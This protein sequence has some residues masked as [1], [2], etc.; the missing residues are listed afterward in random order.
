MGM[1]M[2]DVP[3]SEPDPGNLESTKA[4]PN[5]EKF[6][7]LLCNA[8]VQR[9]HQRTWRERRKATRLTLTQLALGLEHLNNGGT[10]VVLLHKLN[11]WPCFTSPEPSSFYLVAKN[12]QADSTLAKALVL[13]W[14][15]RYKVAT[16]GTDEKS[17]DGS[18]DNGN[19]CVGRR[20]L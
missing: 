16:V 5:L 11:S 10:M 15:K 20:V 3:T 17:P 19:D 14:K 2:D 8:A 6:D 18:K 12:I 7:L 1:Q 4:F 9:T 13:E